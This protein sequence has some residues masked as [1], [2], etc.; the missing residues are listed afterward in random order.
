MKKFVIILL[1]FPQLAFGTYSEFYCQNGGSNLN[2]CSTNNN[3][4]VY[5][6]VHGDWTNTTAVYTVKDGTNASSTVSVGMWA[7]VYIDGATVGVYI[8]RISAVQNATNG[9]ITVDAAGIGAKPANQTAT[10]TIVVGGACQ[11]PNAASGFPLTLA[12]WGLNVDSTSHRTRLNLKNDQTYSLTSSFA[13]A[14][15]GGVGYVIQGYTGTVGDGG[16]ATFDGG[17]STGALISSFGTGGATIADC[18]FTTSITTGTTVDVVVTG[19]AVFFVRCVFTGARRHGVTMSAANGIFQECEAYNNNRSNSANGAGFNTAANSV[20]FIR[21]NSHDNTG[22]LTSGY[23]VTGDTEMLHCIA[24]TNGLRGVNCTTTTANLNAYGCD[25]YNNGEDGIHIVAATTPW[26]WIEN[27]NFI[28]NVG[29]GINNA[30]VINSGFAFNNGYGAGTQANGSADT[31]NNI[32][33]SGAVTYA[34]N[35]TPWVDPA[36]GDFSINLAAAQGVGRGAF[37][38]TAASYAG[39]V[40]YPDIGAAQAQ[41]GCTFPTPTSTPTAT[42]TATATSTATFTPTATS[43]ATATATASFTPCFPTPTATATFTPTATA[44]STATSTA[45]ATATATAT[46]VINNVIYGE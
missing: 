15:S 10:A 6:A 12:T 37:T 9:T 24:D 28:K 20:I 18:I 14:G 31:L 34:S 26:Q 25:F 44:T 16:K 19:I 30:S 32:T 40:G 8:G 17:T 43:T 2:A 35:V 11:G 33:S 22:S 39:T 23:T 5:T 21:C 36:N 1:L 41:I 38:E 4:P 7:S 3:T 46:P 42:A 13:V 45:T 29:A 27:C